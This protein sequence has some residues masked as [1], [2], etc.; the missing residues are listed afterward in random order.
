MSLNGRPTPW[1]NHIIG[2]LGNIVGDTALNVIL[3]EEVFD[4]TAETLVYNL[5]TLTQ[6]LPGLDNAALFPRVRANAN[7][8]VSRRSHFLA[9]LPPRFASLVVDNKGYTVKQ[10][11]TVLTQCFQDENCVDQMSPIDQWLRLTLHATGQNDTGP[12]ATH[13]A[14]ESPFLDQDLVNHRLPFCNVLRGL[15]PQAPGLETAIVQFATA[16]NSQV[17]E[18]QTTRLIRELERDQS[19]TPSVK[20]D[21]LFDS[22]LNY[23]NVATEQ[24]LPDFWFRFATAKKKQEFGTVRDALEKYA[25]GPQAFG[26][27]APIPTPKLLSDFSSITFVGEHADDT[28]TG[29]QP[30]MEMDGS[31]DFRAAAHELARTYTML[32]ERE[33]GI[34]FSDLDNFKLP[35]DV[36]GHP[37]TFFE[38]EKSL[39]IFD[40]LIGAIL[41]NQHPLTTAYCTFWTSFSSEYKARL[42]H[43]IDSRKFI[44]PVHILRSIQ[45]IIFNWFNAKK[46]RRTPSALQFL[47][48]LERLSNYAYSN[49]VL[50]PA[51]YQLINPKPATCLQPPPTVSDDGSTQ[52]GMSSV[53]GATGLSRFTN[54]SRLW[55]SSS[56]SFARSHLGRPTP[57]NRTSERPNRK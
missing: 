30:F 6:E 27:F 8:A 39:I 16:V 15:Q 33:L 50:P 25:R 1:D 2:F 57:C 23:L 42:H 17:A 3:P 12:P 43:E 4:V 18:S 20:F 34:S 26:P 37:T 22:L 36:R 9:Y 51:L 45:L 38:L 31:E 52:S 13:L 19:T 21:M 40:N 41:G 53:T 24:E 56:Q 11:W 5:D 49:P 29:L 7:N 10:I 28:K 48:I 55:I 47:D 14:L 44:K 54:Q 46:M 32:S 35:K